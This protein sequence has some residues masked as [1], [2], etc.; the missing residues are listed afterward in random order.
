MTATPV[1]EDGNVLSNRKAANTMTVFIQ[2]VDPGR[3][4]TFAEGLQASWELLVD[5]AQ[6]VVLLAG[7]V[8]PFF[9]VPI[10][11]WLA[12]R[13]TKR[14]SDRDRVTPEQPIDAPEADLPATAEPDQTAGGELTRGGDSQGPV[15]QSLVAKSA[16]QRPFEPTDRIEVLRGAR[17]LVTV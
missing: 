11:I 12:W 8:I 14:R 10:L 6:V 9:W 7:A 5:V 13:Y 1:N 16:P 3:I 4:P 15:Q 2:A 17:V